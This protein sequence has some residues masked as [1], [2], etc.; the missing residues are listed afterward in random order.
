MRWTLGNVLVRVED[1]SDA[2][3]AWLADFLK[4]KRT[5]FVA[6]GAGEKPH[7][8]DV[9][10]SLFEMTTGTFPMGLATQVFNEAK[11]RGYAVQIADDRVCPAAPDESV[12][13]SWLTRHPAVQGPITHQLEAV[14]TAGKRR[15][16]ILW[17]P[18]GGG[19]GHIAV[20]IS[21]YIPCHWLFLVHR[22]SLLGQQAQRYTD[23]TGKPAGLIRD[24]KVEIPE[25][26][27]FVVCSFQTMRA[28]LR[29]GR[30]DVLVVLRGCEGLLVDECHGLAADTYFDVSRHATRAYYRIG[31][32]GTPLARTAG[33]NLKTIGALGPVIYR[34]QPQT[35]I[36][37]GLLA[38]P[39]IRFLDLAQ[40]G[41]GQDWA[42]VYNECVVRSALRN[43]RVMEAV[44]RAPKPC[45]VFVNELEHGQELL[46]RCTAAGMAAEFVWGKKSLKEREAAVQRLVRT[47]TEVLICNVIFQEGIDVPSLRSVVVAAGGQST[48]AAVQRLGRGIRADQKT[49][50]TAFD[51]YDIWDTG[52]GC[53][54]ADIQHD[55]CKWLEKHTLQRVRAYKTEGYDVLREPEGQQQLL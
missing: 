55:A 7:P 3:R 50:K 46:R 45:M 14:H 1:E 16:G 25:G 2:E 4:F 18:T 22:T 34:V 38:R 27:R 33:E 52:C 42:A 26:C 13:L 29:A 44:R 20:G 48:V 53:T 43:T 31:L 6:G 54:P 11:R 10:Q 49:G 17:V 47:D 41:D 15:R 39:T 30:K 37:L 24:G 8:R 51:V 23:I 32:S 40:T 36:D 28:A 5:V 12:D 35:L 21:E 9:P 19:K